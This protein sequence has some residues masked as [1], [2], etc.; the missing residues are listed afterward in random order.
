MITIGDERIES[1]PRCRRIAGSGSQSSVG[2]TVEVL[3]EGVPRWFRRGA[4]MRH[5]TTHRASNRLSIARGDWELRPR[6]AGSGPLQRAHRGSAH[7]RRCARRRQQCAARTRLDPPFPAGTQRGVGFFDR[8]RHEYG[9]RRLRTWS[10]RHSAPNSNTRSKGCALARRRI[11]LARRSVAVRRNSLSRR[12]SGGRALAS[13]HPLDDSG[14]SSV[15]RIRRETH[16]RRKRRLRDVF[17]WPGT[18]APHVHR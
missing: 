14:R 18:R 4:G 17:R 9:D 5:R 13:E 7:L 15:G 16:V 3:I 1:L 10:P 6:G 11:Q 2:A 12:R 8:H